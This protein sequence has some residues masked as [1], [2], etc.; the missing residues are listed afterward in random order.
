MHAYFVQ[1]V[2]H[3]RDTPRPIIA[4]LERN[5]LGSLPSFCANMYTEEVHLCVVFETW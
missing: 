4:S 1:T 5:I 2:H 3:G